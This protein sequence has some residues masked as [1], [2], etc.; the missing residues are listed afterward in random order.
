MTLILLSDWVL[1]LHMGLYTNQVSH[2][3]L[4][5]LLGF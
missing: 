1:N 2:L 3:I 4:Y 5:A